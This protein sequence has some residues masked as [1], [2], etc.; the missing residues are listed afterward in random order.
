[1]ENNKRNL[2]YFEAQSMREL[3]G[4]MEE[5]QGEN[6]KRLLSANIQ[7]EGN[8]FSCIALTNPSEVI[9]VDGSQ[10]GGAAVQAI[11]NFVKINHLATVAQKCFPG[12]AQVQT[13]TGFTPIAAIEAG[14]L[15]VSYRSDGTTTLRPV[16]R[17]L[18][19]PH[20]K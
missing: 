18:I 14:D 9:I 16:T 4:K 12:S 6:H 8:G 7:R 20:A 13:A 10:H 15:V 2:V 11:G 1:M 5:W 17:K 3:Y 19:H